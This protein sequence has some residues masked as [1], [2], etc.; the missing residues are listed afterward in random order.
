MHRR[1]RKS[2]T[3]SLLAPCRS[4][5]PVARDAVLEP[6]RSERL[7]QSFIA[8]A[9]VAS[10]TFH[11]RESGL[12]GVG[13]TGDVLA[14][15]DASRGP[16]EAVPTVG[17]API[18]PAA[19]VGDG[20]AGD[21][22][23]G[24]DDDGDESHAPR[25]VARLGAG[26]VDPP[27]GALLIPRVPSWPPLPASVSH[28][29][30]P[31]TSTSAAPAPRS[32]TGSRRGDTA[33]P[34]SCASRTPT[35]SAPRRS[36]VQAIL[37]GLQLAGHRLGR[38]PRGGRPYGPYFQTSG[39]DSYR[40]HGRPAHRRGQGLPLLLHQGGAGRAARARRGG[41]AR[42]ATSTRAPAGTA[43]TSPGSAARG[44]LPDAGRRGHASPSTTR[45]SGRSPSST[46]TWTTW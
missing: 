14:E 35:R 5:K 6:M 18:G 23:R 1:L 40:E 31:A 16:A 13:R 15:L 38:G 41:E 26:R 17:G 11:R 39:C 44:P 25:R 32:S 22:G 2:S 43:R 33:A 20:R 27:G 45:C 37:D 3:F 42:R 8:V 10:E 24:G 4:S 12:S 34:S 9:Q 29:R 7:P 46:R 19:H 30:P 36:R 28:P 21:Q